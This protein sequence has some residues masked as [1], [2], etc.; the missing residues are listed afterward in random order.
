MF[1]MTPYRSERGLAPR[2]FFDDFTGDFFKPFLEGPFGGILRPERAMKV[3]VRDD[4]DHYT[5]EADMPGVSKD[6]LKVEVSGGVLTLSADYDQTK[7]DKDADERYVYRER[8]CGSV[9]RSFNVEGIREED[10]TAR[11]QD[12]VLTLELPKRE[13]PAAPETRTI[14][15]Q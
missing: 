11:F 14:E 3:D 2:G 7:E 1:S 5:L 9:R 8:R 13:A 4:G 6:N 15:I 12:G 10:I